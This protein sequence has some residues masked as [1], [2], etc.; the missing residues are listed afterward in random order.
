MYTVLEG[1]LFSGQLW[2]RAAR[3][4][5]LPAAPAADSDA[6]AAEL[7]Q[8]LMGKYGLSLSE[9]QDWLHPNGKSGSI[10]KE[11]STGT[12]SLAFQD[13]S[14]ML[15]MRQDIYCLGKRNPLQRLRW[16]TG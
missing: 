12:V 8:K 7:A 2:R 14:A 13:H 4:D 1:V 9:L 3:G 5:G 10:A 16:L 6:P 15:Q 11:H